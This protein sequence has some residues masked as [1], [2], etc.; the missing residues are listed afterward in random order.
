MMDNLTNEGQIEPFIIVTP[1]GR[2]GKDYKNTSFDVMALFYEFGKELRNDLIPYIDA[3]YSTYG[4]KADGSPEDPEEA[5]KHRACAGLSMGGMQTINIGM[6]ECMDLFGYFGTYSAAPTS[7]EGPKI[8]EILDKDFPEE[9]IY[10][11]YNICGTD[12]TTA[13]AS[14]TAAVKGLDARTDRLEDHVNYLWQE[15]P[16]GHG[17]DIWYLGFYNSAR[18]FFGNAYR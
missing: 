6:C 9:Q 10:F 7:Y 1:N 14:A 17:W 12:D 3:N 11:S 18:I 15:R 4:T 2:S 5:R 8:V 13:L 16:G